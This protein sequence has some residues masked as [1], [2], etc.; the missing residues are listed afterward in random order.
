MST[1]FIQLDANQ[2]HNHS[3][4]AFCEQLEDAPD[5]V[6]HLIDIIKE[7]IEFRYETVSN[8]LDGIVDGAQENPVEITTMILNNENVTYVDI[9]RF[10]SLLED[11]YRSIH[12]TMIQVGPPEGIRNFKTHQ[13]NET[14]IGF[15]GYQV[16]S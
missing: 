14:L 6:D 5:T 16:L 10:A 2:W 4:P 7:Y 1:F 3:L 9:Q 8:V 15:S 11:L 13:N 12:V